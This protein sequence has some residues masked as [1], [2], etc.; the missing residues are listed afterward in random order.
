M[1][2]GGWFPVGN[3]WGVVHRGGPARSIERERG[4]TMTDK[5]KLAA[6]AVEVY[7]ILEGMERA[8]T[9]QLDQIALDRAA[10][11]ALFSELGVSFSDI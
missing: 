4:T 7:G 11:E 8:A 5:D 1:Q 3:P 9:D 6:L 10:L 2:G